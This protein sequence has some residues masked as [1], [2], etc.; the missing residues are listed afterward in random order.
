[1]VDADSSTIDKISQ[2]YEGYN[3]ENKS[4]QKRL[5]KRYHSRYGYAVSPY[6]DERRL[7]SAASRNDV[8]R[9]QELLEKGVNPNHPDENGRTALHLACCRGFHE[10]VRSLLAYNA[11]CNA[12]DKLG[13]TPLHLAV[14]TTSKITIDLLLKAGCCVSKRGNNGCTPL[15]LAQSK[16]LLIRR[17]KPLDYND[18]IRELSEVVDMMKKLVTDKSEE[19]QLVNAFSTQLSLRQTSDE[20]V[21]DVKQLLD[22]LSNLSINKSLTNSGASQLPKTSETEK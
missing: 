9:V 14:C 16:L 22:S 7:R 11:N 4:T 13:N 3:H 1:M 21:E 19:A 18:L 17:H 20:V 10:V 2:P 12:V 8:D 5:K 6:L 15:Q